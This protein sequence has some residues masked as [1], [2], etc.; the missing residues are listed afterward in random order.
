LHAQLDLTERKRLRRLEADLAHMNR[1]S[2]MGEQA[3][4]LAHEVKQPIAAARNNACAALNFLDR[5]P[6]DL[7]EVRE[8]LGCVVSDADRA[9]N[10]IDRIRDHI[11]KAPPRKHR[12]DLN[13]AINEVIV[14]AQGAIT[15]NRVSVQT[16]LTDGLFPVQGDRVQLQQV[17]L[18]LILNAIEAMSSVEAGARELLI[19]SE[20][21]QTNGAL[22]A[23]RDSGPGIDPERL[24]RVFEA[25]YTTKSSGVGM[26]LSICRSIIDGH[27]GRLWA[28]ANEPRG[29]AFQ[30]TLPS[31]EK[32]LMN[33][34]QAAQQNGK[35]HE[36][37]V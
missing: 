22:V 17:V 14:L 2:I 4:S 30:F 7:D 9:G 28:E 29:A 37:T 31:A 6:P 34:R 13:E 24:E 10:I 11:R 32:E 25:F 3:A 16:H 18:N 20:Q 23:V 27:G 12:F 35:P 8:A 26:G 15:K 19:S 5:Q 21:S 1:L 33:S 36:D